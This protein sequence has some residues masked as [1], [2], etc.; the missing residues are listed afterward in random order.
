VADL[1]GRRGLN[2]F[3][4][5]RIGSPLAMLRKIDPDLILLTGWHAWPLLQV[6]F[7]AWWAGIPVIM[8]GESNGLRG[9]RW[10]T[11]AFH[12]VL[13]GRCAAFL[14]IGRANRDF[15]RSY[16]VA[17]K[18]MF[19][20]PYF[21][22]NVRF[23]ESAAQYR[24][25]RAQLRQRWG[26][27]AD[28]VCFCYAGKLEP[29]KR[30]L[31]VL[32]AVPV[33][34]AQF[35]GRLHLLV[36]GT[37]ELLARAQAYASEHRLPVT[38]T[39]FL[40]QT[41]IPEAYIASDCLVLASDYGETWGLVVNEA[42]V[43]GLPAI[44]SDR[45]G[46]VPDLVNDGQTGLIFPFGDVPSLAARMLELATDTAR[47]KRMGEAARERVLAQYCVAKAVSGTLEAVHYA[48]AAR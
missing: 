35:G 4:S 22:D 3:F 31:D 25:I 26:I 37:G 21:V 27:A 46:S 30:I 28:A 2:G 23:S 17:D 47:M 12:R 20:A 24:P 18:C 29:K 41:E 19:D 13:L 45:V 15:Y 10:P 14:A 48:L 44:V 11:R 5:A 9:R 8:R 1:R 40:N 6:L 32:A 7:A 36:V 42:M 38:F 16:G 43:C 34:A 33:A 39:G